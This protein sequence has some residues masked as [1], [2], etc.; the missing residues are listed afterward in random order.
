MRA[1][2]NVIFEAGYFIGKL[3]R[4]HTIIISDENIEI[5]TDLQGIVYTN[6]TDWK[7]S[8]LK[9]LRAIGYSIDYN[10]IEQ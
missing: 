4:E 7:L 9:E 1:R 2:Q 10:K 3:G 5:P 8:I 6:S